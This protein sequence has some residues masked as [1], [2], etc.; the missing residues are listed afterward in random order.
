ML[1]RNVS[2]AKFEGYTQLEIHTFV[3]AI[4]CIGMYQFQNLKD[5]HNKLDTKY[6]RFSISK[7]NFRLC[8]PYYKHT[9]LYVYRHKIHGKVT[10]SFYHLQVSSENYAES[11]IL[12][13]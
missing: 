2:I 5:I 11:H 13:A 7:N 1:Y 12:F 8:I 6:P 4:G 10:I 3:K 9:I